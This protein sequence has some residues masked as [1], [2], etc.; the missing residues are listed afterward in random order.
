ML[1]YTPAELIELK[2]V[3]VKGTDD[4]ALYTKNPADIMQTYGKV[5]VFN[6]LLIRS[7]PAAAKP[8]AG[9][10]LYHTIPG[11]L[12]NLHRADAP[13]NLGFLSDSATTDNDL[14]IKDLSWDLS[15]YAETDRIVFD[16][17]STS[18]ITI[19]VIAGTIALITK[20]TSST[21]AYPI[22]AL[23]YPSHI[24]NEHTNL[25][26]VYNRGDDVTEESYML[27]YLG[28]SD[29]S[30]KIELSGNDVLHHSLVS[31][32]ETKFL[33]ECLTDAVI[34]NRLGNVINYLPTCE[35]SLGFVEEDGSIS[36]AP[37]SAPI[38]ELD[39]GDPQS[40]HTPDFITNSL[41]ELYRLEIN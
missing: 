32:L 41:Y 25:K 23:N 1:R 14:V 17:L 15:K 30:F 18:K 16:G 8:V 40:R 26:R 10:P 35:P 33:T 13:P 21:E 4:L 27:N 36:V 2:A 31:K 6:N 22:E 9:Q 12:K 5:M 29:I 11:V 34:V 28:M 38:R 39:E 37:H 20:A 19:I 24:R 3:A 7:L